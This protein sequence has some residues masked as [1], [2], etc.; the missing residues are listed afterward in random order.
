MVQEPY[1]KFDALA[2]TL[3]ADRTGNTI[4]S[5]VATKKHC[6]FCGATLP[7]AGFG[8][9][10]SRNNINARCATSGSANSARARNGRC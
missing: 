4:E 8:G 6:D 9:G 3:N 1:R 7:D 10:W 2:E 5:D